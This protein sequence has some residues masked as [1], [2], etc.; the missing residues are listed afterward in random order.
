MDLDTDTGNRLNDID[1]QLH[2][3]KNQVK[4]TEE[5]AAQVKKIDEKV[6]DLAKVSKEGHQAV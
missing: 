2:E 3:I 5:L 1:A 4:K 6:E